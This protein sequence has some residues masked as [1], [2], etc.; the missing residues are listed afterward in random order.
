MNETKVQKYIQFPLCWLGKIAT[1]PRQGIEKA[2]SFGVMKCSINT[3]YTHED[4]ARQVLYEYYHGET[5]D[6]IDIWLSKNG[7]NRDEDYRGFFR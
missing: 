7:F 3:K 6:F 2:I 4:V 5:S 1:S